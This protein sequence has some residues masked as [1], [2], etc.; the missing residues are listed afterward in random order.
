MEMPHST[1]IV[2]N[3]LAHVAIAGLWEPA[4]RVIQRERAGVSRMSDAETFAD[5]AEVEMRRRGVSRAQEICAVTDGA[6]W[7]Q[8]FLDLHCPDAVRIL[9]FPHAGIRS[10][11]KLTNERVCIHQKGA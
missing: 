7:L 2:C 1:Q 9:D 8:G 4:L 6:D 11:G 10:R 3:I 5:L